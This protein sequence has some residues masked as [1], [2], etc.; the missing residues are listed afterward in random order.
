MKLCFTVLL[1]ILLLTPFFGCQSNI[2][3]ITETEFM[4]DTVITITIYDGSPKAL[5]GAIKLCREYEAL[6]SKTAPTSDVYKI[7]TSGG[8]AVP[9]SSATAELLN[10]ALNICEKSGGAF[11]PTV[12]PLVEL[13][14]MKNRTVPPTDKQ[15]KELLAY[16]SYNNI[17]ITDNTVTVGGNTKIDLGGIAKGFIAD[18]IKEYLVASGIQSAVINLGGNTLLIG[19][20]D[21]D[22]FTVGLQKPFA[23]NGEL[24]A[25]LKLTD[26]TAVTSGTY[27]RYFESEGKIYHHIIDPATGYPADN[28]LISVT[29]VADSSSVADGLSTACLNLGIE[30]GTALAEKYGAELIFI[31]T[32][33]NLTTT[34]GLTKTHSGSEI[35]IELIPK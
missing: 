27:Q 29:V 21:G 11:D 13:W 28:G 3:P 35:I 2:Y 19:N 22:D 26:K 24:S 5:N 17:K 8:T 15:I 14:D 23:K 25:I 9:V 16:V 4:L 12:F 20:K 1:C 33:G 30:K 31:D 32:D 7:N 10:I 6:L 34:D 18:K